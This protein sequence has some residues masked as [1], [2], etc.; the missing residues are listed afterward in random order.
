MKYLIL[1]IGMIP[2]FYC[3]MAIFSGSIIGLAE[4]VT[5]IIAVLLSLKT[6]CGFRFWSKWARAYEGV[7]SLLK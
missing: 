3:V 1:T 2:I 7:L 6:K 4:G 5:I